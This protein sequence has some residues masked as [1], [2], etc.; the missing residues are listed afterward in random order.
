MS[1]IIDEN[2]YYKCSECKQLHL[3]LSD[4]NKCQSSHFEKRPRINNN[5]IEI[6]D[7]PIEDKIKKKEK[8]IQTLLPPEDEEQILSL[9]KK[10]SEGN[11][12][13]TLADKLMKQYIE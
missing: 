2:R 9:D 11:D 10:E 6:S 4:A 1:K 12:L 8:V 3:S 5:K 7:K 13:Q